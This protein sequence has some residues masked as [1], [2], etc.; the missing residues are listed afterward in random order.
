MKK[1]GA[2]SAPRKVSMY[3]PALSRGQLGGGSGF[4]LP[5]IAHTVTLAVT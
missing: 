5:V 3:T 4:L 1:F 2:A